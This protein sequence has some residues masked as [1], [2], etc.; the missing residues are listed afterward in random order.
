MDFSG[1]SAKGFFSWVESR[2][3]DNRPIESRAFYAA[4]AVKRAA[5][6]RNSLGEPSTRQ[7]IAK[8]RSIR[9]H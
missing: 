1:V 7:R 8:T 9:P 5:C 4:S 3:P 2:I 6:A